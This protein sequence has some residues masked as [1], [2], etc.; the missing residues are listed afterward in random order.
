MEER[1]NLKKYIDTIKEK[2]FIKFRIYNKC[3][4]GK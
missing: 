1:I 4:G 3:W 2:R